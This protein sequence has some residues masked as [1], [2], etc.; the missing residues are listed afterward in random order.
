MALDELHKLQAENAE[1]RRQLANRPPTQSATGNLSPASLHAGWEAEKRRIL[2]MLENTTEEASAQANGSQ[3]PCNDIRTT[4]TTPSEKKSF[5][6]NQAEGKRPA[7]ATNAEQLAAQSCTDEL[8]RAERER[9]NQLQN[10]LQEKLRQ[11]EVEL[12]LER[13]KLARQR[14]ELEERLRTVQAGTQPSPTNEPTCSYSPRRRQWLARLGLLEDE[15]KDPRQ[16]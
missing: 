16:R 4:E 9:L 7:A 8:L 6:Q 12:S 5:A 1:L 13:A 10:E 15:S 14:A 11:A 3:T 2:A